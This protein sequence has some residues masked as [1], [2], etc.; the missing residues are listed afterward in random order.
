MPDLILLG[1]KLI[2][3]LYCWFKS[4]R[5]NNRENNDENISTTL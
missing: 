2:S 3:Y 5:I 1:I 4:L